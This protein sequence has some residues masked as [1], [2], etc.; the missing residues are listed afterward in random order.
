[1]ETIALEQVRHIIDRMALAI[2]A[3]LPNSDPIALLLNNLGG[4]SNLEMGVVLQDLLSTPLGE[5]CQLLIGPAHL[6]T[7][8]DMRGFS[9]SA[10]PLDKTI[11]GALK[12]S[13]SNF[14]AWPGTRVIGRATVR[15]APTFLRTPNPESS[16]NPEIGALIQQVC[17]ALIE[18][19]DLLNKLDAQVGDGDTGSTFA[20]AGRRLLRDIHL[21]SLNDTPSLFYQL[22]SILSTSMGGS[23]GVLLSIFFESA[24]TSLSSDGNLMDALSNGLNSLQAY[25]GANV[26]D[27][28]MVDALSPAL[29]ALR[30]GTIAKATQAALAGA[31]STAKMSSAK[32]GRSAYVGSEHLSDVQDPGAVAVSIIFEAISSKGSRSRPAL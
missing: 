13:V 5:R 19:E 26:G 28:T 1:V 18:S 3:R 30:S 29:M 6:M 8:L 23:T 12:S 22:S 10:L 4:V 21:L 2:D 20:A 32:A 16:E 24:G 9:I 27:R 11:A 15:E 31:M 14:T 25:G 17:R 7:S